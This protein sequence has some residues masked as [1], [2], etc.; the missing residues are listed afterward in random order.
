[1]RAGGGRAKARVVLGGPQGPT[2][3]GPALPAAT[4][5]AFGHFAGAR[6]GSRTAG[7]DTALAAGDT[8]RLRPAAPGLPATTLKT[9]APGPLAAGDTD[10]DGRT[11]LALAPAE[12]A[13]AVT[14]LPG[15]GTGLDAA[16]AVTVTPP[17]GKGDAVQLLALADYDGDGRADLVLRTVHGATR[18]TVTVHP[19]TAKG[20]AARPS[21]SFTS[22]DLLPR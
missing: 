15:A 8:L 6:G 22:A 10:G 1:M 17:G 7:L 20:T 12:G 18:D 11:D 14:V 21:L 2:R 19:G 4:A 5:H 13:R 16:R 9:P 3:P